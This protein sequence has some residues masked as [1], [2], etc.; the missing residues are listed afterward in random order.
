MRDARCPQA[1]ERLLKCLVCIRCERIPLDLMECTKC[2]GIVC[3]GCA[4]QIKKTS[5]QCPDP[6]CQAESFDVQKFSSKIMLKQLKEQDIEHS[7]AVRAS[8]RV[9]FANELKREQKI[10]AK[11]KKNEEEE[12]AEKET[13]D[14]GFQKYKVADLFT[15][16][17]FDCRKNQKECPLCKVQFD[18]AADCHHHIKAICDLVEIQCDTCDH[19]F[20]R[21]KFKKHICYHR[22][23]NFRTVI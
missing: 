2:K 11:L 12:K 1:L 10:H 3:N 18:N 23:N 19:M 9:E 16:L 4:T 13:D 15:H 17:R 21:K 6:D 20:L 5:Q 14:E 7:C 8:D 22:S